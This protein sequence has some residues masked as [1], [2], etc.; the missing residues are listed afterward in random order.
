MNAVQNS[1]KNHAVHSHIR[2]KMH[3]RS[4]LIVKNKTP[5]PESKSLE[6]YIY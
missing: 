6:K 5:N 2:I 3:W 4:S 1:I